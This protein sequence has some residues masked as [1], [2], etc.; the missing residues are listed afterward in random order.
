MAVA[1]T[2]TEINS[3]INELKALADAGAK[4]DGDNKLK[5][6][7]RIAHLRKK[8]TTTG[9]TNA[10]SDDLNDLATKANTT[11]TAGKTPIVGIGW[12]LIGLAD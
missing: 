2:I 3:I 4:L 8:T 1:D 7:Q 9:I 11:G 12:R 6:E 5:I 10:L